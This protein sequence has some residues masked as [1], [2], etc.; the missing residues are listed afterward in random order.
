MKKRFHMPS[1]NRGTSRTTYENADLTINICTVDRQE[2]LLAALDSLLQTTP[3]GVALNMMFNGS[4]PEMVAA[5]QSRIDAWKGPTNVEVLD[6]IIPVTDSHNHALSLIRTPLV[7][8]M[9]DDDVV[10]GERVPVILDAFNE[11]EEEPVVVTTFAKRVA[12]DAHN[13]R[14]GSNKDMGPTT[15]AEWKVW[16][17]EGRMFE[18]LWPGAVLNTGALRSIGGFEKQFERTFDNRIFTRLSTVGP[19]LSL[20]DRN[21]G[22]RIH[23]GSLSTSKFI[24]GSQQIRHVQ[25]CRTA[26]LE[27]RPAPTQEEFAQSERDAPAYRRAHV[28]LRSRSRMHF[29]RGSA[30]L[31]EGGRIPE[32]TGQLAASAILWPPAFLEKLLDQGKPLDALRRLGRS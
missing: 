26:E 13:P 27:G 11:L 4:P 29:R 3:E 5:T 18:M 28:Y 10:L 2:Q 14:I 6:E 30:F 1:D 32:A 21:F 24:V 22:F 9:G 25:A 7:N 8:F 31:F 12:G 15:I 23:E 19:T 17:D 20:S 16:R